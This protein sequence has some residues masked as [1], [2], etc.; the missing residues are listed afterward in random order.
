MQKLII[1]YVDLIR[2]F[3]ERYMGRGDRKF[4]MFEIDDTTPYTKLRTDITRKHLVYCNNVVEIE[5]RRINEFENKF[6]SF[7][8]K[9]KI[10]DSKHEIGTY[11]GLASVLKELV[12]VINTLEH[13]GLGEFDVIAQ[14]YKLKRDGMITS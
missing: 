1:K 10:E 11:M 9:R 6:F 8:Y 2:H 12:K 14:V 13:K 5:K 4:D 7:M 3:N